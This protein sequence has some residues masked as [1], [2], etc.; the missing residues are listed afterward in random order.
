VLLGERHELGV[1]VGVGRHRGGRQDCPG[2]DRDQR[3]GV[4]IGV[5]V[6]ADDDLDQFCEHGHAF[7]VPGGRNCRSGPVRRSAGL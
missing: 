6:D 3:G 7:S 4:S 1:A 5:G 2:V